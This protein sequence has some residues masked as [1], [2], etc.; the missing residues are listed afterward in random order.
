MYFSDVFGPIKWHIL[1]CAAVFY[2]VPAIGYIVP[3][4]MIVHVLMAASLLN[5]LVILITCIS[6][7]IRHGFIWYYPLIVAFLYAPTLMLFPQLSSVANIIIYAVTGYVC[8]T[9]GIIIR[10]IIERNQ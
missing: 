8:L 4:N 5:N 2:L 9:M 1:A 3:E 7:A 10:K 6:V